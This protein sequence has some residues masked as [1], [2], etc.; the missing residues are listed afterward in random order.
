MISPFPYLPIRFVVQD[1]AEEVLALIDTGFDGH[2]AAPERLSSD[3]P[4]PLYVRRV[5][6]AS[7]EVVQVPVYLGTVELTDQPGAFQAL[8]ILL[9]DEYLLGLP[10]L[11]YFRIILDHGRSVIVEP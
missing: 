10:S 3:L 6:M 5:R 4:S 11:S 9:G 2:L 7:G 1:R 8:I